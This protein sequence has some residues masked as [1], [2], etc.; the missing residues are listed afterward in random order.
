MAVTVQAF[1]LIQPVG[2][3][4]TAW[5]PSQN[6]ETMVTAAL[7][8][9]RTAVEGNAQIA[10]ADHNRAAAAHVYARLYR[11][12]ASRLAATPQTVT[13][14]GQVTRVYDSARVSYFQGLANAKDAEY[15]GY[16][17]VAATSAGSASARAR[18]V[19]TW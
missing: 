1:E 6:L 9:A 14:A 2:E 5:F 3:L 18:A 8:D 7:A 12:V 16:I 11:A 17:V 4:D 15:A 19:P 13:I 10:A